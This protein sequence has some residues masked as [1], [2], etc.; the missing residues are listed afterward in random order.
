MSL[1][2]WDPFQ[3]LNRFDDDWGFVPMI[4]RNIMR[5]PAVDISQTDTEVI[6]D[7]EIPA[8]IDPEKV[9]ISVEGDMLTVRGQT[10][11]KH[12]E[13]EK[14]YYRKE[15]RSGSF[16]RSMTLPALVKGDQADAEYEKGILKIRLPKA[17]EAKLKKVTVKMK[18]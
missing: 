6:V 12:E 10:D 14:N 5:L 13:K 7:L 17:E 18:K 15:I 2:R 3:E 16:E 11:E 9:D 4:R 1:I 8:G